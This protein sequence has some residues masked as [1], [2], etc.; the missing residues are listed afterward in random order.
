MTRPPLPDG[1]VAVVKRDCPTCELVEPVLVELCDALA[2]AR[3]VTQDDPDF[4]DLGPA[5]HPVPVVHDDDLAVSWHWDVETVP[6]LLRIRDGEEVERIVGWDRARW[7]AFAEL[8]DLGEGLPDWRPGCGSLSVDPARADEL[9]ARFSASGLR[10]RRVEVAELEDEHEAM[11]DRGWSDGLPLVPPT[12]ARVA[13]MLEGT[14]RDPGDV[15]ATVPPDLVDCTVEKVAVNAVMAGCRPEYLP[16]VLAAVEAACGRAFN[17][18]GLLATTFFSGPILIVNGPIRERI[19]MNWGVNA[20]GQGNRANSTIGRAV[21]LVI[22]NVGGGKPGGVDR[23]TL[24][25]PG[26]VGFCFAE[27]E[28][29]SP[30]TPLSVARG[31]AP[32][33]DAVTLFAGHGP[34]SIIDQQ[35][36]DPDSLCRSLAAVLRANA[37][38]KLP[39]KIDAVLVLSPEH[40][41]VFRDA[42]WDRDRFTARMGELL[43]LDTDDLIRGV[44]G[45]AEGL[46]AG[47][48]GMQ[49]PKFRDGGLLVCHAG[50]GAGLFSAVLGGW[51]NGEEGSDPVTV[52]IGP[53][54]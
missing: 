46:P 41:R 18:H 31:M 29:G 52:P 5:A 10:S 32:D 1:I 44:D 53:W 36:R 26:K 8:P 6:T 42:G 23:A 43:L 14:S 47:F 25:S 40:G 7:V 54:V 13:R 17:A 49:L 51:V 4:P 15:V 21:Q 2:L 16:V 50:G 9:A 37:H 11:W 24:G 45:C 30:F 12:E 20:L 33:E 22:R 27:D 34:T 39:L 35:S 48:E 19:G 28:A 3:V 38:P